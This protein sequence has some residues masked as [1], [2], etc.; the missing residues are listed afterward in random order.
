DGRSL[1]FSRKTRKGWRVMVTRRDGKIGPGGWGDLEETGLPVGYHH[2]TLMPDGKTMFLQGPLENGRSGLFLSTRTG[3]EWSK[4]EPIEGLNH[5]EGK[6]GSQS[7]NL[8][9]DGKLLYFASD[10]KGTKGGLDIWVVSTEQV[11]KKK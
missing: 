5:A 9:R 11:L 8:S 10:R 6:I 4:P 7:P 2:A 1:Y 3:K